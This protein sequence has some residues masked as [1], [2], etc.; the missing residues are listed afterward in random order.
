MSIIKPAVKKLAKPFT[1]RLLLRMDA[2][3]AAVREQVITLQ[4]DLQSDIDELKRCLPTVLNVISSQSAAAREWKRAELELAGKIEQV[5][6][7]LARKIEQTE[8]RGE[9][10]RREAMFEAR[11][12]AQARGPDTQQEP[13]IIDAGKVAAARACI[14]LNLGCG[15]IPL[16]G[17]L[18]VDARNLPGVDIRADV[19]R[20][21]FEAG[22]VSEIFSAHLLEHFPVEELSRTLLP[23]WH[24][25]LEPGGKFSAVVP[26]AQTMITEYSAGRLRFDDLRQ[27]TFGLQEYDGDFHFNMF[28]PE[29]LTELLEGA[30]F[31]EVQ[32]RETGRRNGACYEMEVAASKPL[33]GSVRELQVSGATRI[34][35]ASVDMRSS[36][37]STSSPHPTST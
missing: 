26:D 22:E 33:P 7:E 19:G 8:Q 32:V 11:Y 13:E 24:S 27:V 17:Y 34:S 30:G 25:L 5:E 15:H 21:P 10:I 18:N 3:A 29:S 2:R 37:W 31:E 35:H 6:L 28:T 4:S 9:F 23:Y 36:N 16:E 20:L 12:G 1:R 14:R